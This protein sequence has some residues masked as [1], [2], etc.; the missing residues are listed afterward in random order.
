VNLLE[1]KIGLSNIKSTNLFIS[2]KMNR[3][4]FVFLLTACLAMGCVKSINRSMVVGIYEADLK[5]GAE[6]LDLRPNGN[7]LYSHRGAQGKVLT[8]TN[9]WKFVCI[10]GKPSVILSEFVFELSGYTA[11]KM[12]DKDSDD[13]YHHLRFYNLRTGGYLTLDPGHSFRLEEKVITDPISSLPSNPE[14]WKVFF[15]STH[16]PA[17]KTDPDGLESEPCEEYEPCADDPLLL[18]DSPECDE[19]GDKTYLG[20]NMRCFCKCAGDC[21]WSTQVR[22]CLRCMDKKDT[23]FV[24]AHKKCYAAADEAGL[25]RP[26]FRLGYCYVRC[27]FVDGN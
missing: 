5:K 16:D 27:L 2:K 11:P 1:E 22:G 21:H 25:N 4:L 6:Y 7:Y 9:K 3:L 13:P 24:T 26:T 10:D 23:P 12:A 14:E 19:Y 17:N 20:A 18:M 8:D 15:Y